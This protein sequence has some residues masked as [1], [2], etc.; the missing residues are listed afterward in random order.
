MS[1]ETVQLIGNIAFTFFF[2]LPNSYFIITTTGGKPWPKL[3]KTTNDGS[4]KVRFPSGKA[5]KARIM[6][7][8]VD[9]YFFAVNDNWFKLG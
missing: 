6:V 3:A 5:K 1:R 2:H 4:A 8:A 7:E 9:N